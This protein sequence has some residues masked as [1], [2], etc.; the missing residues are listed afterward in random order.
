[1]IRHKVALV[2]TL[3]TLTLLLAQEQLQVGY[4]VIEADQ[5]TVLPVSSALF[6]L[7]LNGIL[8]SEAG[9][10]A[11]E[12]IQRG[13]LF[14]DSGTPTGLALAN[15]S[16]LDVEATLILRDALGIV[17]GQQLIRVPARQH[18]ARFVSELEELGQLPPGSVG[19]LTF[20]TT[21]NQGLAPL[22]IRQS[23]NAHME[24]LL[25]TLPVVDLDTPSEPAGDPGVRPVIFPHLGAGGGL[26]TQIILI[27]P[28]SETISGEIRL[29][30]SEGLPLSLLLDGVLGSSFD[31][32]L[33][34][35]GVLQA[36]LTSDS[37][38]FSGYATVTVAEGT[39]APAGTAIFQFRDD[40]GALISEAGVG[41]GV[42]TTRARIFVDNVDTRTGLAV[43]NSG[44]EATDV[45]FRLLD[46]RGQE[47]ETV[48]RQLPADGHL[49]IFS[50]ELFEQL[51]DGFTGMLEIFCQVPLVPVTLKLTINERADPILTTLPVADLTRSGPGRQLVYPQVGFGSG[52]STRFILIST[53]L[54][55][56]S[57][58]NLMLVRSSGEEL[59]TVL[60]GGTA[61][62]F[63]YLTT[64]GG[65]RSLGTENSVEVAQ[66]HLDPNQ[67]QLTE[68]VINE[69]SAVTLN[70]LVVDVDGI[71]R[72]DVPVEMV[73]LDAQVADSENGQL[74]GHQAG[75]STLTV[76]AGGALQTATLTVVRVSTGA[77]GFE[78]NG[79][80]EDLSGRLYLSSRARHLVL[81][82]KDLADVPE[83]YAGEDGLPGLVNADKLESRFDSPGSLA[84]DQA[85]G[86][87]FV[88]DSQ[89][90]VIR[91]V[92]LTAAPVLTLAGT[93]QPGSRDGAAGEATFRSPTGVALDGRG[94]LWVADSGNHA[95][96]RIDLSAGT[97]ETVAGRAGEPGLRDG[98]AGEA[99]FD[100]PTG[101]A[102]IRESLAVQL[103]RELRGEPPTQVRA[104]VA[105]RG[106]NALRIVTEDGTVVTVG[107]AGDEPSGLHLQASPSG[108]QPANFN[109]PRGV[110]VDQV[111]NL[112]VSQ[113]DGT[114]TTVLTTG[115]IVN[116]AEPGTFDSRQDVAVGGGG[117]VLVADSDRSRELTFG[118]PAI[119]AIEPSEI[120]IA[121]GEQVSV[122]GRNFAPETIL[123]LD[124]QIIAGVVLNTST[125]RFETPALTSGLKTLTLQNRGGIAQAPIDIPPPGLDE[126]SPGHITT[127]AGGSDFS[128]DGGPARLAN[129]RAPSSLALDS[130]GN[131]Y[132]SDTENH[133][134]RK[135][136]PATGVITSVVGT[137]RPALGPDGR[138][139][140]ASSLIGPRGIAFDG[141]GNLYIGQGGRL[142]RVDAATGIL[143]TIAGT[144]S[145]GPVGDG[146][147]ALEAWVEP[148]D[149]DVDS[150]GNLYIA[151]AFNARVRRV[152]AASGIITTIAGTGVH[153]AAGDGGPATEAQVEAF[154]VV[155]D[156][157][158]NVYLA[159]RSNDRV[160]RIDKVT[161]VIET[162]LGGGTTA[163][164]G[165]PGTEWVLVGPGSLALDKT[166]QLFVGSEIN[167]VRLDL[168]SE[169]A[170]RVIGFG[171][172][173][174][175]DGVPAAD[176]F[177]RA[178]VGL[179]IDAAGNT[180][181]NEVETN[182]T[183]RIDSVTRQLR[184]VAGRESGVT[185]DGR[186]A[187]QA[188]LLEPRGIAIDGDGILYIG[189][190]FNDRIRRV[191]A[192]TGRIDTVAGGGHEFPGD[193]RP[194]NEGVLLTVS[195]VDL[196]TGTLQTLAGT[197][198]QQLPPGQAEGGPAID[199]AVEG[200]PG[201][202]VDPAGHLYMA[203]PSLARVR[204][205]DLSS[206]TI[207]TVAGTGLPGFS[208]DGGPADQAQLIGP[209]AVAFDPVGNLLIA[210]DG[211][212]RRVEALSGV[213]TTLAGTGEVNAIDGDFGPATEAAIGS[214][215]GL[216]VD[217]H[218]N[219]FLS[220]SD[221]IRRIDAGTGII[222][223]V[224]GGDRNEPLGDEGPALEASFQGPRGLALDPEENLLVADA[225][226]GR[227]RGIRT[228][229]P[230]DPCVTE[231]TRP[232]SGGGAITHNFEFDDGLSD[233]LGGPDLIGTGTVA[234]GEYQFQA[235]Q[236]LELAAAFA[237]PG[238]YS[239]ELV[240]SLE[241]TNG[242]N[243][244]IDFGELATD[245]GFYLVDGFIELF[246][247]GRADRQIE[248][249]QQVHLV[250]TRREI[251]DRIILY[252][253]GELVTEHQD[254]QGL[255][256]GQESGRL[257]FFMD[258]QATGAEASAG[259][260]ERIRI[261]KGILTAEEVADL[262]AG[263]PP[264]TR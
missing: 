242:Y 196:A 86:S 238:N 77:A 104:V 253:D 31:Y 57:S 255:A 179:A 46:L 146:G 17:V 158:G 187:T 111:G 65:A 243:K 7:R 49:G 188:I 13:R 160:R 91:F 37:G 177:V 225:A 75:F 254:P 70:P 96:R 1:M 5:D 216:V 26:T 145:Q 12:P 30:S 264:P 115:D 56:G 38:V 72:D 129:L 184:R 132:I 206:G 249:N 3:F 84:F 42:P 78:I 90:H 220:G 16:D 23:T 54:E 25:A 195:A 169:Q 190:A 189:E 223:T 172:Q 68:I 259:R 163:E 8:V 191:D 202:A 165:R 83:T 138:L 247:V 80:S 211:R 241:R 79:I 246:R 153:G 207:N 193:G 133:R 35:N 248:N 168:T 213:I 98:E 218:G 142:L 126:I 157:D 20:D 131:L 93:G 113:G 22:T 147:L 219:V 166:G 43:A 127:V 224:A 217:P 71:V 124:G 99:R 244:L 261:Y 260:V 82:A 85:A 171:S 47:I 74:V 204:R 29:N 118:A 175:D 203:E 109:D 141:A 173:A 24:P 154:A 92:P 14:V 67:L 110:A 108:S 151:D 212:I 174:A 103:D 235:N 176:A 62:Q 55:A 185:G 139:A 63:R 64:P 97:V 95:V 210:G 161:G 228:P 81:L 240:F 232:C 199:A 21:S 236:G 2:V 135:V 231:A 51:P 137:G 159:D 234:S 181:F 6:S 102:I 60:A 130:Q 50:D 252:Q 152:E 122:R 28:I 144:G 53:D 11:V 40:R 105:D 107:S 33:R 39:R 114:L 116:A 170:F 125:I 134:V 140:V 52:F 61:S 250:I 208:G 143:S 222:V 180:Y 186:A 41:V 262:F 123:V 9:V 257:F 15:P 87:L 205:I 27:N 164:D 178:A 233:A 120:R 58:G 34:P 32:E 73:S 201:L 215:L 117:R 89:N 128:G 239:M 198:G 229:F 10:S 251:D 214:L 200:V 36:T 226:R 230:L 66:I 112:F 192:Q 69:G 197:T 227:I 258:D 48:V 148:F 94:F 4:G 121:G 45:S 156:D 100:S 119:T 245:D 101:I 106:N 59:T 194:A 19:S 263:G 167:I 155:V 136:D 183:F 182:Q 221:R 237:G 149:T 162:I 18:Q 76:S 88:A 150:A 209:G 256:R 44:N